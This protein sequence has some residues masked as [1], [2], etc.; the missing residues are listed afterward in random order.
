MYTFFFIYIMFYEK[1]KGWIKILLFQN[2]YNCTQQIDPAEFQR[3][4]DE[5]DNLKKVAET[6]NTSKN[7]VEAE[8][9]KIQRELEQSKHNI[10]KFQTVAAGF[11]RRYEQVDT[12][13]KE[14]KAKVK[15][16]KKSQ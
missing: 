16:R 14:E 4:K 12:Q 3:I 1:T 13:L 9:K 7:E 6:A 2:N 5:C 10:Q 15:E 11:K 8:L